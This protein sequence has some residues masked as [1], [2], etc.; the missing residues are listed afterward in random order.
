MKSNYSFNAELISN[1]KFTEAQLEKIKAEL[2]AREDYSRFYQIFSDSVEI[3]FNGYI[4]IYVEDFYFDL[5]LSSDVEDMIDEIDDIIP[6]KW[7]NDSK[8]E[9]H[10]NIPPITYIWYKDGKEWKEVAKNPDRED[11]FSSDNWIEGDIEESGSR[12]YSD[13]D[14][15]DSAY[16]FD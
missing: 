9:F 10:S 5:D 6:G 3:N 11:L 7:S 16:F 8:V 4:E 1:K 15:D 13:Y 12:G 14:E 2:E